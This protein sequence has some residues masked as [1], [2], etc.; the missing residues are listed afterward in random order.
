MATELFGHNQSAYNAAI[1][2]LAERS[3]AAVIHPDGTGKSFIGFRL[4]ED[5]PSK[6][7]LWL[8]PS[9][10]TFRKQLANWTSAGGSALDHVTFLTYAELMLLSEQKLRKIRPD[11]EVCDE[12]H[13][14]GPYCRQGIA[15]LRAL[16]PDVPMLGLSAVSSQNPAFQ[17]EMTDEQFDGNIASE[18][19]LGEAIVRGIL[20]PPKY[21]LAISSYEKDLE[22]YKLRMQSAAHQSDEPEAC[23]EAL[24][25]TLAH[26]DSPDVIFEKYMTDR[27]G[28][29]IV[30]MPDSDAIQD[31][32]DKAE[33]WFGKLDREMHVYTACSGD[34]NTN[35]A[36]HAFRTDKS[37][38]LR[39]LYCKDTVPGDAC[40]E[41]VSGVILLRPVVSQLR[42]QQQLGCLL[43]AAKTHELVIF[44]VV[45]RIE[46]LYSIDAVK[47][48]MR[49]AVHAIRSQGGGKMIVNEH[50]PVMNDLT[51]CK[52]LA[53][54]L[55]GMLA[56]TW[57]RMY[58][59]AEAY[60]QEHHSLDPPRLS[61][62]STSLSSWLMLQRRV[63]SGKVNGILTD[64]QIEKLDRIG[65]QWDSETDIAWNK[66]Y[67]AAKDYVR[68]T[69]SLT[70]LA[71]YV[72]EN[73]VRLGAWLVQLR[74]ARRIGLN[75]SY[76]TPEHITQLDAIGMVWD[77]Y[78]YVFERNYY[79]A[80]DYYRECGNLECGFNY[81]DRQ[82]IRLG[83]WLSY[84]RQQYKL[85][86]RAILT[87][88]QFRLLDEIGMRWGSKYDR[89]W[90]EYYNCLTSY[91][92][93]TGN[94]D[95]PAT[96]KEGAVPLGRW[97]RRQKEL[98]SAGQL[99]SDRAEKL[100]ALGLNLTVEDPWE[101]RFQLAKAYS[102]AHSGSLNVPHDYVVDG[103]WLNKWLSEQRLMGEGK[104]K[105]QLTPDQR[106]KLESIGMVFG[107]SHLRQAWEAHYLALR[108]YVERTGSTDI[109]GDLRDGRANLK[110]W[111]LRQISY[112]REGKLSE[113]YA[114]KLKAIGFELDESSPFQIGFAHA[115]A[116]AGQHG[117]LHVKA[118]YV[119]E[120]GYGLASWIAAMRQKKRK[121]KLTAEQIRR[122]EAIGMVWN[123]MDD[124]WEEMLDAAKAF[125]VSGKPLVIPVHYRAPNGRDLYE[126]YLRQRRLYIAGKLSA[127]RIQKLQSIGAEM[128]PGIRQTAGLPGG[129]AHY[130][131]NA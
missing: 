51:A 60:Y 18:L 90:D 122:L 59:A 130:R 97:Y 121:G 81:V 99:R 58:A 35:G 84:L 79:S 10:Q 44:D 28:K 66:Y 111:L 25:C 52:E 1:A 126:W 62:D 109:P 45:S 115:K 119:C 77:V 128:M 16:Y 125:Y 100:Q 2:M 27:H 4:C 112:S 105:K 92:E 108:D 75:S 116:Y 6:R 53:E 9:E 106:Q 31:Y 88:D 117:D 103:I 11:I 65:M 72:T 26:A 19:T 98:Y 101:L 107:Q 63:R 40:D 71:T 73:G 20:N 67:S 123:V 89:Q 50:F 29:Y 129:D 23:L 120:D 82:G 13:C 17:Q 80:V 104:R 102:E 86:G 95:V 8:S 69:G 55:E 78:D 3:R 49:K 70:P 56:G 57:D 110:S 74:T 33:L 34:L 76:L 21:I 24:A 14:G 96:W 32:P 41:T 38:H 91:L 118:G 131:K 46:N 87:E 43:S 113:E 85:H 124:A 61:G 5:N 47:D 54:Q 94:R 12:Y 127:E 42:Y 15:R 36:F 7:I 83:A 68:K 39:L 93:R 30:M 48:E 64:E 37:D 22:K 114:E